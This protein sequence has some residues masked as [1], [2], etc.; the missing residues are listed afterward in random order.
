MSGGSA[1][2]PADEM[3]RNSD[4]EPV[5]DFPKEGEKEYPAYL[6]RMQELRAA[7]MWGF[8]DLLRTAFPERYDIDDDVPLAA[9]NQLLADIKYVSGYNFTALCT[10]EPVTY[11]D[12]E[13]AFVDFGKTH[14]IDMEPCICFHG[15]SYASVTKIQKHGF[16][17]EL[18]MAEGAYVGGAE[19]PCAYV[20]QNLSEALVYAQIDEIDTLWVVYGRAHLGNPSSQKSQSAARA[21]LTSAYTQTAGR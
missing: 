7:L 16:N 14:K 10:D 5:H 1:K 11:K 2:A 15:S 21:R 19:K 8:T 20:S 3:P 13:K 9:F 12:W 18:C 4:K 17:P 6:E